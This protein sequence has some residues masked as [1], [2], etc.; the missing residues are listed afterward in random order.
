MDFE[1]LTGRIQVQEFTNEAHRQVIEEKDAALVLLN[2]NLKNREHDHVA[3]QA[4]RDVYKYQLQKFQDII[5]H[6]R[7]HYVIMQRTMAKATLL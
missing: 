2:D 7:T 5:A 1:N 3:L 4:Q 6:L